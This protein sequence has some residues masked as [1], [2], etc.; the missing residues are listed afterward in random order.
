MVLIVT[1]ILESGNIFLF[2]FYAISVKEHG[3]FKILICGHTYEW[4]FIL[5]RKSIYWY[6]L[7]DV[8]Y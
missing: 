2:T 7:R 3:I 8:Y 5:D 6:S 4:F 1:V